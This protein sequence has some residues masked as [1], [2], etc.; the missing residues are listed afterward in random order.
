METDSSWD[1]IAASRYVSLTTFRKSGERVST[2]MWIARDGDAVIMSTHVDSGKVKRLRNN[3]S[4][5][6]RP[7]SAGGSV[8][9][10]IE[11][12]A[13]TAELIFD[14]V[15]RDPL[16]ERLHEKY[17]LQQRLLAWLERRRGGRSTDRVMLRITPD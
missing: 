14:Q 9:S 1:A 3:P 8:K 17:G 7:S 16:V 13:G 5:E 15:R 10:G 4:V 12:V 11:P 6:L 2:A